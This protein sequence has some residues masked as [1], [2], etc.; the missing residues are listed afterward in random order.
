R[1]G[2]RRPGGSPLSCLGYIRGVPWGSLRRTARPFPL[3][4][5]FPSSDAYSLRGYE[6]IL[7]LQSNTRFR[8]AARR[9]RLTGFHVIDRHFLPGVTT[10]SAAAMMDGRG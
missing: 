1:E 7:P 9:L 6:R 3:A 4:L 2:R 8:R 10:F 5:E